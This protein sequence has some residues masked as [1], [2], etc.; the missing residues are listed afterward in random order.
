LQASSSERI[1]GQAERRNKMEK[2]EIEVMNIRSEHPDRLE[3]REMEKPLLD[4]RDMVAILSIICSAL[5][6]YLLCD[7]GVFSWETERELAGIVLGMMV[8]GV[9]VF[10]WIPQKI[11]RTCYLQAKRKA[12]DYR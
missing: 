8:L 11:V 7:K 2:K 12:Q 3:V 4:N 5:V 10:Y 6:T 1:L 9:I